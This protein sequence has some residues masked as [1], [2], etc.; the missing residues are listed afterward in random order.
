MPTQGEDLDADGGVQ[1]AQILARLLELPNY[2]WDTEIPPFHSVRPARIHAR[3]ASHIA[4]K[5]VH[6]PSGV[7]R[8]VRWGNSRCNVCPRFPDSV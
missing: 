8:L 7:L 6:L 2:S 3:G 4:N 1:F 5:P